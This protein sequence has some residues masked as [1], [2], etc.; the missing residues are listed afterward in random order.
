MPVWIMRQAGRYLP[1]FR[2]IRSRHDFLT[3]CKTPELATEVTLQ[4]LDAIGVDAA[5]L[6]ADILLPLE[7]MGAELRF[8]KGLGPVFPR[9]VRGREQL[10]ELDR[11]AAP[12]ELVDERLGYVF[13]AL[14]MVRRELDGRVPLIGFAG[15]PWTLSTYLV[16]GGTSK[17]FSH[18]LAW[19]YRDPDGLAELLERIADISLPYLRG[20]V[21]A[22][23]QALQI[24]DSWGGLLS[25]E[26]WRQVALPPLTRILDGLQELRAGG[27]PLIFYI[28]GGSHLLPALAELP[29]DVLSVDWRLPLTAVRAAVDGDIAGNG[30]VGKGRVGKGRVLQGNLDPATLLGPLDGIERGVARMLADGGSLVTGRGHVGNLGHG[31]MK[32]TPVEHARA[33]VEAVQRLSARETVGAD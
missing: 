25:E 11:S 9:P 1:Q 5:I 17:Q 12:S 26:R 29:V 16:E 10:A 19:S 18:L 32:E 22:G 8:E 2:A 20:Q 7:A 13:D 27:V 14:R 15:T 24:F 31:I 28:N 4:P 23:A 30:R 3:V 33:F 6:F 21:A